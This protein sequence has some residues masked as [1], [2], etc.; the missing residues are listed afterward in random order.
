MSALKLIALAG[1]VSIVA[2]QQ[3]GPVCEGNPTNKIRGCDKYG[4]G[5]FGAPRKDSKGGHR[6]VDVICHDGSQIM[7]PFDGVITKVNIYIHGSTHE[8]VEIRGGG[9]CVRLLPVRIAV[10]IK[11]GR[12]RRGDVIGR[13]LNMQQEFPGIISH[14]HVE[15]C[16]YSDPTPNLRPVPPSPPLPPSPLPPPPP[17]F[18]WAAVCQNNP[19]N[20]IRG[21]D[22]YGCGYFGAPRKN[23]KGRHAGVD[24]ICHDGFTVYAPFSGQL[25]GPIRPFSNGNAIDNGIQIEGGGFCVKL[26]CI[27]PDTYSG[28]VRKGQRIGRMLPM[29]Q[30]FP[31]I[32]SHIHVE[33]CDRSDP[34]FQLTNGQ[35]GQET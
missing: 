8:G 10:H 20:K 32:T 31:G 9:F 21:C 15:N 35:Q 13:M 11:A 5:H 7:A 4:C 2:A 30:V 26:L 16:D 18:G 23:G 17:Q 28:Y 1:L 6:G 33:N 3:W 25:S 24:V 19:S 34:T 14:I 27:R 12:V 29:Q 22:S